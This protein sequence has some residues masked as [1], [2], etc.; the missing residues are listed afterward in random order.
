MLSSGVAVRDLSCQDNVRCPLGPPTVYS[1]QVSG[2]SNDN[3]A[4]G[5]ILNQTTNQATNK[6]VFRL[7]STDAT[8]LSKTRK[9]KD[10]IDT[11]SNH[12]RYAG[13][14]V[15]EKA[16]DR[17]RRTSARTAILMNN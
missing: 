2:I 17:L 8:K 3:N 16:K 13:T 10:N 14:F 11:C 4:T 15:L 1:E 5:Q 6:A 9:T 12:C 7:Q